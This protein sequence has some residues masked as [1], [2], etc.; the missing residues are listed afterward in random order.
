MT[1]AR[2]Y[3]G[4]ITNSTPTITNEGFAFH[5]RLMLSLQVQR[6]AAQPS[7]EDIM[8]GVGNE[9]DLLL[10]WMTTGLPDHLG[11]LEEER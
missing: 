6:E 7:E 5:T 2:I 4:S 3:C 1:T 11:R 8:L 10:T 9:A